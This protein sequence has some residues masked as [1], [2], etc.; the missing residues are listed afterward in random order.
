MAESIDDTFQR[1]ILKAEA[2]P[3]FIRLGKSLGNITSLLLLLAF[4]N[5]VLIT[6]AGYYI[7]IVYLVTPMLVA[8][9]GFQGVRHK[10]FVV[11]HQMLTCF[12]TWSAISA[13]GML[14][15]GAGAIL[16]LVALFQFDNDDCTVQTISQT[17]ETGCVCAISGEEVSWDGVFTPCKTSMK[18]IRV[19]AI[20]AASC[21]LLTSAVFCIGFKRG[22]QLSAQNLRNASLSFQLP[23]APVYEQPVVIMATTEASLPRPEN[24]IVGTGL[25]PMNRISLSLPPTEE[26]KEE[27]ATSEELGTEYVLRISDPNE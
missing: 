26:N 3:T 9:C 15:L 10:S 27:L 18:A 8:L 5:F 25:N 7:G 16:F 17:N 6:V 4:S 23:V 2:D 20:L 22:R 12:T 13:M 11:R 1:V 21:A 14:L 19:V 24:T